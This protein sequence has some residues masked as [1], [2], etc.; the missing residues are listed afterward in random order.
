[1]TTRLLLILSILVFVSVETS[2]AE[3]V[4][5]RTDAGY[6]IVK[7][8][9]D[10]SPPVVGTNTLTVA[11]RDGRSHAAVE[12]AVLE[13]VPWMT[14]HGHGSS[15]KARVE[16]IGKGEYEVDNVYFTM[17]GDWDVLIT[18][19]KGDIKDTASVTFKNIKK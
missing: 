8:R 2:F 9:A 4:E 12:G 7:L 3:T 10:P 16:E 19:H 1:M 5:K 17:E 14:L 18:V 15:K 6:F 13:V 11:V